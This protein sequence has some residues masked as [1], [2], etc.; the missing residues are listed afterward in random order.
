[1]STGHDSRV[2]HGEAHVKPGLYCGWLWLGDSG[3]CRGNVDSFVSELS[4]AGIY[5][6]V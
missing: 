2:S 3:K 6:A 5:E 1:M 4:P